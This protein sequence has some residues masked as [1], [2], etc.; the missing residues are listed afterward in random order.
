MHKEHRKAND[1][2]KIYK[3]YN[4][5]IVFKFVHIVSPQTAKRKKAVANLIHK[6]TT[7]VCFCDD[8]Q[9]ICINAV[10]ISMLFTTPA[11]ITPKQVL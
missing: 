10:Q 9:D 6:F 8:S 5:V 7:A 2:D 3:I 11:Q 1:K 4:R